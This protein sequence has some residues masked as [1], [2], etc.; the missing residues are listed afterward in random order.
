MF[1][2]TQVQLIRSRRVLENAMND[3]AL[4]AL[5]W[6]KQ[7]DAPERLEEGLVVDSGRN[8]ELIFVR[9]EDETPVVAQ[10]VVNAVIGS[11]DEIY[12][13]AGGNQIGA[14]LEQLRDVEARYRREYNR[15]RSDITA[16]TGRYGL[17]PAVLQAAK[18]ERL[19]AA[20]RQRA[21]AERA[22]SGIGS[23][24]DA[25]PNDGDPVGPIVFELEKIY[26]DLELS[27]QSR[28]IA[29]LEFGRVRQ[30]YRE[31]SIAWKRARRE[32][33]YR[34]TQ[35]R[36]QY[37]M[38]L[39]YWER[40]PNRALPGGEVGRVYEGWP[41]VQLER[42][43]ALLDEETE[44][45]RQEIQGLSGDINLLNDKRDEEETIKG[46]LARAEAR[47]QELK[48][49]EKNIAGRISV[50]QQGYRPARLRRARPPRRLR[51]GVRLRPELRPVLPV[52]HARSPRVRRG[53]AAAGRRREPAAAARRGPGAGWGGLRRRGG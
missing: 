16:I 3:D 44:S 23:L 45:L 8:S 7:E 17:D 50:E 48:T 33:E 36:E 25:G 41:R 37:A 31:D 49:E 13:Q 42:E 26:P 53:A 29:R 34:E 4:R 39:D 30:R 5:D 2:Q 9:F 10:T 14:I 35:F 19:D 52:G 20:R 1:V 15:V 38:A 6:S 21:A 46:Q 28:D 24:E 22:L 11:Y 18:R 27:R 12:G 43:I 51:A 32:L 47:I 40:L